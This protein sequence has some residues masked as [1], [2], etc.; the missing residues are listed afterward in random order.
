MLGRRERLWRRTRLGLLLSAVGLLVSW[1]PIVAVLGAIFLSVGS[2]FLFLGARAAGRKH[3]VAVVVAY[4][5]LTVAGA[6]IG[7]L[8][9]AFLLQAYDASQRGLP[10]SDLRGTAALMLWASLPAS[11]A[12]T[13]GL[14]LQ[15]AFLVPRE[16]WRLM[17]VLA[18][19]LGVTA[20]A[21][22]WLANAD[23][24]ALGFAPVRA[25]AIAD[26]LIRVSVYRILEAPAYVGLALLYFTEHWRAAAPI[27]TPSPVAGPNPE[28]G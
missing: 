28:N 17:S 12:L 22:T 11:F 20:T 1:I 4:L 18:A 5:V 3:E 9:S 8:L 10:L 21:A 7:V 19:A 24:A 26:F 15:V 25:S 13:A 23:V 2:T 6:I 16:R 14:V 27:L